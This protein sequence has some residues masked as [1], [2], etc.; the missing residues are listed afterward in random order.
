MTFVLRPDVLATMD[1]SDRAICRAWNVRERAITT[2]QGRGYDRSEV[3]DHYAE[4]FEIWDRLNA[5][6]DLPI[7][8]WTTYDASIGIIYEDSPHA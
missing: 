7:S 5:K 6:Y 2:V 8:P 4:L 1:A 3:E